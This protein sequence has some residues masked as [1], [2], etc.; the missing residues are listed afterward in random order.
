MKGLS[1]FSG[2][3]V[4]L[5]LPTR[6]KRGNDSQNGDGN[7]AVLLNFSDPYSFFFQFLKIPMDFPINIYK[8]QEGS[9]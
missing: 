8:S 7:F 2:N 1:L 6:S 5:N 3:T 9:E 4:Y